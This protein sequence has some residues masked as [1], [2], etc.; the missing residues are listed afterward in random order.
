MQ[1]S[2]STMQDGRACLNNKHI[3]LQQLRAHDVIYMFT[4]KLIGHDVTYMFTVKLIRH[5][6]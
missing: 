5:A 2:I 4:V 1:F 6:V 3:L